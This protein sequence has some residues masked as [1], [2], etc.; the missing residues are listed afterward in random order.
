[1]KPTGTIDTPGCKRC[2]DCCRGFGV[3]MPQKFDRQWYEL[4]HIQ[5]ISEPVFDQQGTLYKEGMLYVPLPCRNLEMTAEGAVC[6]DYANRQPV[7]RAYLCPK[8]GGSTESLSTT[9]YPADSD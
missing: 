4:H 2:G 7:C 6:T 9:D 1:M 5:V 8:A 3:A